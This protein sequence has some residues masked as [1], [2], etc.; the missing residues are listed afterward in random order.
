MRDVG[1]LTSGV[2]RSLANRRFCLYFRRVNG[3]WRHWSLLLKCGTAIPIVDFCKIAAWW[4]TDPTIRD[5]AGWRRTSSNRGPRFPGLRSSPYRALTTSGLL[6][7]RINCHEIT[8]VLT[9]TTFRPLA[10]C[11]RP[12]TLGWATLFS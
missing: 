11:S 6:G 10:E 2:N 7:A 1:H 3:C 4:R 5:K 12:V 8:D 9:S